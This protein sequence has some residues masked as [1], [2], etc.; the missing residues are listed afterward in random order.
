MSSSSIAFTAVGLISLSVSI[1]QPGLA[2]VLVLVALG[3]F[4]WSIR[5]GRP[6]ADHGTTRWLAV[7]VAGIPVLSVL[8]GRDDLPESLLDV[9]VYV[10]AG[11]VVAAVTALSLAGA[12]SVRRRRLLALVVLAGAVTVTGFMIANEWNSGLGTDVYHAHRAAGTALL[13]G[14]NPYTDAV[15]FFD[16]S[17]YAPAG[18][19]Y[20]GYPYPPL[21]LITYGLVAAFTDPRLVSTI[22]WLGLLAWSAY[23]YAWAAPGTD[24]E[25]TLGPFLLLATA[26]AW[27]LL[28]FAAWTEPL[29]LF[30]FLVAA[31]LWRRGALVSGV[32]LGL[33]L[34]SKQYFVV[35]APFLILLDSRDGRYRRVLVAF[36]TVVL[37]MLP[38]I[39]L[40]PIA[41]FEAT[42]GNLMS[43]GFRPDTQ[44]IP[45][46]A[47]ALGA[48]FVLPQWV[49]VIVTGVVAVLLG[50]YLHPRGSWVGGS[51]LVLAT[52]FAL[53]LAFANYW[54]LV[55]G[56]MAIGLM[57]STRVEADLDVAAQAVEA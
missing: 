36:A 35:L 15:R 49:V 53:G 10:V 31:L 50:R 13:D 24:R 29:S 18:A 20:E 48:D 4:V 1:A 55:M 39:A 33:A 44:S 22:A 41:Y 16:G 45:G 46:L 14:E 52:M 9:R 19:V 40:D 21:V 17:P 56:L 3:L 26:P 28:W 27:P 8:L 43:I 23:A 25:D 2:V 57:V 47:A 7:L 30:L 6:W 11:G 34:A 37:T 32:T 12:S 42:L 51:A 54:F 38:F 5:T